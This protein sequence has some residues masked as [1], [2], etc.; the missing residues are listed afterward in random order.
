MPRAPLPLAGRTP[1]AIRTLDPMSRA[2][3]AYFAQPPA[4]LQPA[5]RTS[6]R[7]WW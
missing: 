6:W 5:S 2:L 4:E 1:P 7:R 3:D